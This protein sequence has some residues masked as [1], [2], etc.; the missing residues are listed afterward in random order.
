[1]DITGRE[2]RAIGWMMIEHLPAELLQEMC[3]P[4]SCVWP[5]GVDNYSVWGGGWLNRNF[6]KCKKRW[7]SLGARKSGL[8]GRTIKHLP[9]ELLQEMCWPSRHVCAIDLGV[10]ISRNTWLLSW[11]LYSLKSHLI[12]LLLIRPP[13]AAHV[14]DRGIGNY[15]VWGG[16]S[17]VLVSW[18]ARQVK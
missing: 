2:V 9:A 16:G 4:S 17:A 14:V 11:C 3:W 1:M 5:R 13:H 7:K 6:L 10:R 15:S 8:I 18:V 12:N